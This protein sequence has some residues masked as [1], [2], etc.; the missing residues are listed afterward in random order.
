MVEVSF[1]KSQKGEYDAGENGRKP[2][3]S[4]ELCEKK[5][6]ETGKGIAYDNPEVETVKRRGKH[7]LQQIEGI[8]DTEINGAQKGRAG[9][10]IG[11]PEGKGSGGKHLTD[12]DVHGKKKRDA[13]FVCEHIPEKGVKEVDTGDDEKEEKYRRVPEISLHGAHHAGEDVRGDFRKGRLLS[14][15][16][17]A[18]GNVPW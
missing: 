10:E 14:I 17:G 2:P 12:K 5:G 4:D 3:G 1:E 13:V 15:G 9:E 11:V 6:E 16:M 18:A 8:E 7:M